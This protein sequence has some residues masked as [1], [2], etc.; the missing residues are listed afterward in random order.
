MKRLLARCRFLFW[1]EMCDW[2]HWLAFGSWPH[3]FCV[4]QFSK[5]IMAGYDSGW[6]K[7]ETA[8]AVLNDWAYERGVHGRF[9]GTK[10]NVRAPYQRDTYRCELVEIDDSGTVKLWRWFNQDTPQ[11]ARRVA[12]EWLAK[13]DQ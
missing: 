9:W 11:D 7:R 5:A 4:Q 3:R 12:A 10:V 13:R 2:W 1:R 8:G 6:L